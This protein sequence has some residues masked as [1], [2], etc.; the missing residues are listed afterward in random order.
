MAEDKSQGF[1]GWL[2][3]PNSLVALSAAIVSLS[4]FFLVYENPGKLKVV[5]PVEV[6]LKLRGEKLELIVPLTLTNT[7]APRTSRHVV[8]L[9]AEL[10]PQSDQRAEPLVLQWR[11]EWKFVGYLEF[12]KRYP[13][14][15]EPGVEDYI[16][17]VSRAAPFAVVGGQSISKVVVFEQKGGAVDNK[18]L[19]EFR[20]NVTAQTENGRFKQAAAFSCGMKKIGGGV[21]DWC[22]RR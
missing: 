21:F 13:G 3:Q 19:G 5:L 10:R 4:T 2:K 18:V 12:N 16:E 15:G 8:T 17:Y 7:G 6:G 22:E 14:K 20:L 1:V 11:S 9:L